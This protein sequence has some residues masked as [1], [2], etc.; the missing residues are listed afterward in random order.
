MSDWLSKQVQ[1]NETWILSEYE[2]YVH[3]RETVCAHE[4][5]THALLTS[6]YTL[7]ELC[8]EEKK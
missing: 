3:Q 7:C 8:G 2:D 5:T 4:W 1:L 6:T